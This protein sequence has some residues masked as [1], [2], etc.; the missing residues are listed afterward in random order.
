VLQ[1]RCLDILPQRSQ[2]PITGRAT[3][4]FVV[5]VVFAGFSF[6]QP[7][8]EILHKITSAL[9]SE[10]TELIDEVLWSQPKLRD[11]KIENGLTSLQWT[12][13]HGKRKSFDALIRHGA[14][15]DHFAAYFAGRKDEFRRQ[16]RENRRIMEENIGSFG[17]PIFWTIMRHDVDTARYLIEQGAKLE[18]K[19][20]DLGV[21]AYRTPLAF[22]V[23]NN[24]YQI[25]QLLLKHGAN[26]EE[27]AVGFRRPEF[28]DL[29]AR[30]GANFKGKDGRDAL[31]HA[32][33][34]GNP[35]VIRRLLEL[36]ADPTIP[37]D[38]GMTPLLYVLLNY[39]PGQSAWWRVVVQ[40]IL[41]DFVRLGPIQTTI[42]RTCEDRRPA[43][44]MF[45][46]KSPKL[47]FPCALLSNNV[48]LVRKFLKESPKLATEPVQWPVAPFPP[49]YYAARNGYLDIVKLLVD[50]YKVDPDG[51]VGPLEPRNPDAAR[52]RPLF[53]AAAHRRTA[54]VEYLLSKKAAVNARDPV[55]DATPLLAAVQARA[56]YKLIRLLV[57]AGGDIN[58]KDRHKSAPLPSAVRYCDYNVVKLLL[59][60]GANPETGLGTAILFRRTA[61]AELLLERGAPTGA[62]PD[63]SAPAIHW[64]AGRANS[65]QII[66][67]LLK[68][69]SEV[70]ERTQFGSTPLHFAAIFGSVDA[71]EELLTLKANVN[72]RNL[73]R[74]T[75]LHFAAKFGKPQLV[76]FLL[77]HGA[78]AD[79]V[80]KFGKRPLD[81]TVRNPEDKLDPGDD[82][83]RRAA[84]RI[85]REHVAK[86]AKPE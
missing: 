73:D 51:A 39:F 74:I 31:M 70:E 63:G 6:S 40:D 84:A 1:K 35:R 58:A 62:G 48:D 49:V 23:Y 21:V 38:D 71:A 44:E 61:I 57:D 81:Y 53:T 28:A 20:G 32:L 83:G 22:A 41:E 66:R 36:G 29:F 30:H 82:I 14:K 52:E 64:A 24:S 85:L 72:D 17:R 16:I 54:V 18:A 59:D 10:D 80:D 76:Q 68:H 46:A 7:P 34:W 78:D 45:L 37:D 26:P 9:S 77:R 15:V 86:K 33:P 27:E 11:E 50:E 42:I 43:A 79:A 67:V 47:D 19:P 4:A 65:P 75:P 69:G 55:N 8:T 2:S 13:F 12:A 5:I 56:D 25:A 60:R 3:G